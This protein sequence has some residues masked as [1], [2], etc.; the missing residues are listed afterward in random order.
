MFSNLEKLTIPEGEVVKITVGGVTLW[1]RTGSL[2]SAYQRVEWVRA[3]NGIGAYIKLG[4]TFDTAARFKIGFYAESVGTGYLFGAAENSGKIRC[5]VT[6]PHGTSALSS[7]LYG[8][9]QNSY[10]NIRLVLANGLNEIECTLREGF[11]EYRNL[12]TGKSTSASNQISLTMTNELYLFAQNY[13]G[14]PRFGVER[15]VSYFEYYDKN[16][17]LICS[18]TP[19]YRKSDGVIGMYDTV[20]KLFL[21]NAGSGSFTKGAEIELLNITNRTYVP[22]SEP[23]YVESGDAR[24]MVYSECYA[25]FNDGRRGAYPSS[26]ISD[27]TAIPETNGFSFNASSGS[28]YGLEFPVKILG[29]KTYSLNYTLDGGVGGYV[30]LL[31]FN[32]DTTLVSSTPIQDNTSYGAHTLTIT[33]EDGYLYSIAFVYKNPDK[34][35]TVNHILLTEIK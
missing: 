23:A 10:N 9:D 12:T 35:L 22:M 19:C 14:S 33:P 28:G 27:F 6:A 32:K 11:R 20:R 7:E 5:M 30:Y 29:G 1:E 16:D 24:S 2:P 25:V 15:Q 26:K 21:T 4:F 8:T 3:E 31:K 18:L 34:T 13:N 17:E